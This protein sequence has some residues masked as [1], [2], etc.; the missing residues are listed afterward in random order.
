MERGIN[1]NRILK[2]GNKWSLS[3]VVR[4]VGFFLLCVY[5][6]TLPLSLTPWI[7]SSYTS[8]ALYA[9]IAVAFLAI[10]C[11]GKMMLGS[12]AG[13]YLFFV[14]LSGISCFYS[15]AESVS[16][17]STI[18]CGKLFLFCLMVY[19]T[20]DSKKRVEA[21]LSICSLSTMVL[22][23]YLLAT[24]DLTAEEERLGQTL[25]GNANNF[26]SM[27]MIGAMCSVYFIFFGKRN[28]I[29][30]LALIIFIAQVYTL[31]LSG[32]RKYFILPIL[33]LCGMQVM[34]TDRRG[35]THIFR[36]GVI[37]ATI[38][39]AFGWAVFNVSF[40]YEAI[41]YRMEAMFNTLIGKGTG[42]YSMMERQAMQDYAFKIWGDAPVFGNGLNTFSVLAPFGAHCHN[43]YLEILCSIGLVGFLVYYTFFAVLLIKLACRRAMGIWRWYW[44]GVIVCLLLFD[45]GAIS[46]YSFMMQMMV[47]LTTAAIKN[48]W[49]SELPPE[50][51]SVPGSEKNE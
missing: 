26:A 28:S 14:I 45:V 4:F 5:L 21:V 8:M 38:L 27:Y 33:L 6:M 15:A 46:Y 34:R 17:S 32:G 7:P 44:F 48:Q 12:Y 35:R 19:N 16:F 3:G 41:G 2:Q 9:F 23:L 42:D 30:V 49:V 39:L 47:V 29:R 40:L 13:W 10:V 37:A 11:R 25:V 51:K 36:N 20:V 1:T 18:D 31:S 24:G 50:A 43:N 22:F